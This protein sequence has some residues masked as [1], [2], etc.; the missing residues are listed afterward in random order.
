[1]LRAPLPL[2]QSRVC[3]EEAIENFFLGGTIELRN[4]GYLIGIHKEDLEM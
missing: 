2:R 1:V 3:S 4:W